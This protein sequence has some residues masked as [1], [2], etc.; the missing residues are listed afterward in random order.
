M[1]GEKFLVGLRGAKHFSAAFFG[2]FFA[3]F[4]KPFFFHIDLKVFRGQFRSARALRISLLFERFPLG[5]EKNPCFFWWFSLLFPKKA[6]KG[7]S[8][9]KFTT[10]TVFSNSGSLGWGFR[11]SSESLLQQSFRQNKVR[12]IRELVRAK[13]AFF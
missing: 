13:R 9:S 1:G 3:S 6:R 11:H 2:S 4:F 12:P 8:G 7:R 5:R 10:R